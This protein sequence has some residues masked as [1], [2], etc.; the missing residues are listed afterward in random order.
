MNVRLIRRLAL[1]AALVVA[2]AGT[3]TF[4]VMRHGHAGLHPVPA[5]AARS[6]EGQ[7]VIY[8]ISEGVGLLNRNAKRWVGNME[9]HFAATPNGDLSLV[10]VMNGD[11]VDLLA[12]AKSDPDLAARIDR[13]RSKGARFLVCRNTLVS[14]G[15]DPQTDL[16][17]VGPQDIVPAGVAE[18]AYLETK[19]YGYLRP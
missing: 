18:I 1:G 6:Y 16:F 2:T 11:G 15:I 9:N 13:L 17:G 12:A 19:G 5:A 14:R 10:V 7:K 3:T 4:F 8:H